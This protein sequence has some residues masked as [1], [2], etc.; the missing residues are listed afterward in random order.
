LETAYDMHLVEYD[1]AEQV[2]SYLKF[3]FGLGGLCHRAFPNRLLGTFGSRIRQAVLSNVIRGR[4]GEVTVS[5]EA[6]VGV[7]AP[8]RKGGIQGEGHDF[9][10]ARVERIG[11]ADELFQFIGRCWKVRLFIVCCLLYGI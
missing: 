7:E 5:L 4:F 1:E 11:R 6:D 8:L 3:P 9:G 2:V 10:C